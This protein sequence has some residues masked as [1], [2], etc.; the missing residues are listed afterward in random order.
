MICRFVY[1]VCRA[2][3][4]WFIRRLVVSLIFNIWD[5]AGIT[6]NSIVDHLTTTIRENNIILSVCFVT[7][8]VFVVAKVD[9]RIIVLR[10]FR[11]A[12]IVF[13]RRL[14]D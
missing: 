5:V 3:V 4:D 11:T 7:V 2:Y 12:K 8:A 9:V 10:L 6:I 1:S 14:F 13:G